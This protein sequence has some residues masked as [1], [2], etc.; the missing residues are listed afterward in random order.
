MRKLLL[1]SLAAF[2]I[3]MLVFAGPKS[4]KKTTKKKKGKT[5]AVTPPADPKKTE[6][7]KLIEG[8]KRQEGMLCAYTKEGKLLLELGSE[9]FKHDYLLATRLAETSNTGV[10]VAGQMQCE[11]LCFYFSTESINV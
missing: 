8:M 11:P 5:E 10:G 1:V 7:D 3:P 2:C 6:Y 9:A 4:D